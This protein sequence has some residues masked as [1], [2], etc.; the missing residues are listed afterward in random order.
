MKTNKSSNVRHLVAPVAALMIGA[1]SINELGTN[2][3]PD[4]YGK[5]D[6]ME[7]K[8]ATSGLPQIPVASSPTPSTPYL[9]ELFAATVD[10]ASPEAEALARWLVLVTQRTIQGNS[11]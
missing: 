10:L 5:A 4:T 3:L 6:A 7:A 2:N 9:A 11:E 8:A 1:L